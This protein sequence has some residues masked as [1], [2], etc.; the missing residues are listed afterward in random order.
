MSAK[1]R[2]SSNE[3]TIQDVVFSWKK[4]P[5][6]PCEESKKPQLTV[7][8]Q[9]IYDHQGMSSSVKATPQ[10]SPLQNAKTQLQSSLEDSLYI[11]DGTIARAPKTEDL[12]RLKENARG[13]LFSQQVLKETAELGEN[14]VEFSKREKVSGVVFSIDAP[15]VLDLDNALSFRTEEDGSEIIGVHSTDVAAWVRVGSALD[16]AARTRKGT[17]YLKDKGLIIPM[18]PLSLSHGK[19]SLNEGESRLSKS[20]E[21][22]FSPEGKFSHCRV[23]NSQLVNQHRLDEPTATSA[24]KGEGRGRAHPELS[25]ALGRINDLIASNSGRSGT[26]E[27]KK[28]LNLVTTMASTELAQALKKAK[29]EASFRTQAQ[30]NQSS[31]YEPSPGLHAS[32]GVDAYSTF[33]GPMRRFADLDVQR[34]MNRLIEQSPPIGRKQEIDTRMRSLQ[35]DRTNQVKKRPEVRQ[36]IDAT[37][38]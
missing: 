20:V 12:A 29:L 23:F 1:N 6:L 15:D 9:A 19:L 37:R 11:Y 7:W 17:V 26:L 27:F 31:R 32:I 36:W 14:E 22:V 38:K 18:L 30:A 33:T 16:Y 28:L 25:H 8:P 4:E 35:L 13:I 2:F 21:L 5:Q 24:R 10:A 3:K 34:A